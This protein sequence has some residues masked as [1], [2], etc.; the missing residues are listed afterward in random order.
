MLCVGNEVVQ[1]TMRTCGTYMYLGKVGTGTL[2]V[3]I[4]VRCGLVQVTT[5][6]G[7]QPSHVF[8]KIDL[9]QAEAQC[10][11]IVPWLAIPFT[12]TPVGCHPYLATCSCPVFQLSLLT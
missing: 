8:I 6:P 10:R 4:I 5:Q 12:F 1:Q 9:H 2:Y 7:T 3:Q 11:S